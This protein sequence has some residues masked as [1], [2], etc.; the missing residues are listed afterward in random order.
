ARAADSG[1]APA[2]THRRAAL[3]VALVLRH[4][5][6]LQALRLRR[7]LLDRL[8]RTPDQHSADGLR[9]AMT[10][11]CDVAIIGAGP[12]GLVLACALADAGLRVTVLDRQPHA[13]LAYPVADGR[14]IALT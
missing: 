6:A 12:T 3:L 14:E 11:D 2:G 10:D 9:R 1:R 8:R 7:A 5:P 4:R 13:A